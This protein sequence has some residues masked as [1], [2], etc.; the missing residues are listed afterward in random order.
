MLSVSN[1][2]I[3]FMDLALKVASQSTC[4][5]MHG[6]V[7]TK[8]GRPLI[9]APNIDKLIP[10][11]RY[12]EEIRKHFCKD[13][14]LRRERSE[15]THAEAHCI[16]RAA[17]NLKGATLYSARITRKGEKRNSCPCPSCWQ[18]ILIAGIKTVLWLDDNGEIVK[19]RV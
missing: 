14:E 4:K 16:I 15:S 1:N 5:F 18:M 13:A 17:T 10:V 7:I 9:T 12:R 2:D 6:G 11:T 8:H 19:E 3:W